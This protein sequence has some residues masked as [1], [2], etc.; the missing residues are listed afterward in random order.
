MEKSLKSYLESVSEL[1]ERKIL[2]WRKESR[3]FKHKYQAYKNKIRK[4]M[5]Y[6]ERK[7]NIIY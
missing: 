4:M 3:K 6:T 1:T 2:N 7:G 5:R